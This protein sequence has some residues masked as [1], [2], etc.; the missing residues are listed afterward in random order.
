M[1]VPTAVFEIGVA[2]RNN[3]YI[4]LWD[5]WIGGGLT[6]AIGQNAGILKQRYAVE[7]VRKMARQKQYRL[8]EQKMSNKIRLSLSLP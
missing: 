3:S 6:Q 5:S 7:T 2:R 1:H 4:L 8:T